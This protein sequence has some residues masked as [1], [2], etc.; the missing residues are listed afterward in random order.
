MKTIDAILNL[1]NPIRKTHGEAIYE[2]TIFF[3]IFYYF[4]G[5]KHRL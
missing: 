5:I 4:C 3:I 2:K 1:F